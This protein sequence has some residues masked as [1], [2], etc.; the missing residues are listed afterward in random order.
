MSQELH[1]ITLQELHQFFLTLTLEQQEYIL[2][3]EPDEDELSYDSFTNWFNNCT[4]WVH[5]NSDQLSYT[6]TDNDY[7]TFDP[8]YPKETILRKLNS[9]A[10][11]VMRS[12]DNELYGWEQ[13]AWDL[14]YC[15][16]D[17]DVDYQ[18]SYLII[19]SD[20][21]NLYLEQFLENYNNIL[22]E[23]VD[24]TVKQ[25]T[26]WLS[27][28]P[29]KI[30][31]ID[32]KGFQFSMDPYH[33]VANTEVKIIN[34]QVNTPELQIII[35]NNIVKYYANQYLSQNLGLQ[36]IHIYRDFGLIS[37]DTL[38]PNKPKEDQLEEIYILTQSDK[39]STLL[40]AID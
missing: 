34:L 14:G 20:V 40:Y 7:I 1:T 27:N 18:G 5:I 26:N 21:L 28:E 9:W 37:F 16:G 33:T 25:L 24:H 23:I 38:D 29:E 17:Y 13:N 36:I 8:R 3:Q 22:T 31:Y 10:D 19:V 12:Y 11:W 35:I 15:S 32:K 30:I 4:K 6:S 2:G 39:N